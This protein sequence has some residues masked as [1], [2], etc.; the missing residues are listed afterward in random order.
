MNINRSERGQA[1]IIIALALV[2]L[3]GIAGLVIDG[4]NAFQDRQR[5]QNAVDSAAL[6]S[7]H[8][9]IRG[10]DL[11][12]VALTTAAQNG[13][14]NDQVTNLVSLYTPPRDGPHEGDIEYIQVIITSHVNTYFA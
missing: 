9:R 11:V 5:A 13:Y 1:L 7:A 12:A 8:A 3:V 6:A 2:G 4:G 10:E 14:N